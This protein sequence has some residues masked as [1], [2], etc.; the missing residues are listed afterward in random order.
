M[1]ASDDTQLLVWSLR[2]EVLKEIDTRTSQMHHACVSPCGRFVAASGFTP[3]VKV[4]HVLFD[5]SNNFQ[6]VVRAFELKVR[7]AFRLFTLIESYHLGNKFTGSHF[8]CVRFRF[9][10]KL[11]TYGNC[12]KRRHLEA[13]RHR[14]TI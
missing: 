4:W 10:P 9:Q 11:V 3:D 8:G 14:H 13:L 2:G 12:F 1:S 5:R 6:D 7:L